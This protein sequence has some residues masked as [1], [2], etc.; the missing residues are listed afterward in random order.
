M[1]RQ[2]PLGRRTRLARSAR[3]RDIAGGGVMSNE[4]VFILPT[5]YITDVTDHPATNAA[6]ARADFPPGGSTTYD[7]KQTFY[8]HPPEGTPGYNG[9][10]AWE[11]QDPILLKAIKPEAAKAKPP[12]PTSANPA[13]PEVIPATDFAIAVSTSP[14]VCRAP[15]KPC[16]FPVFGQ[17][18]DEKQFA[19]TVRSNGLDLKKWDSA[20]TNTYGDEAGVGKGMVSG[21]QGDVVAPTSHS[22]IV[23]I[24]GQPIIRHRDS[25]TL[26]NGNCPGEYVHVQDVAAHEAPDGDDEEEKGFLGSFWSGMKRT[27][28]TAASGE[29]LVGKIG[30]YLDDPSAMGDDLGDLWESRPSVQDV[31]DFGS[32]AARGVYE[33]GKQTVTD[34]LGTAENVWEWGSGAASDAW[35]SGKSAWEE[36]GFAGATG[37]VLGVGVEV[38]NPFKK[39]EA[40]GDAASGAANMGKAAAARRRGD[41]DDGGDDNDDSDGE[42]GPNKEEE[43]GADGARSTR[44]AR[45]KCFEAPPGIDLDEL[46]RQLAEQTAAIKNMTADDMAYAHWVLERAGGTKK[47]RQPSAQRKARLE[48]REKYVRDNPNLTNAQVDEHMSGLHATHWLDMVAGGDPS[49]I[50]GLGGGEVNSHIGRQWTQDGRAQ[51]LKEQADAMRAAGRSHEKMDVELKRC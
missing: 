37:A 16:P 28:G 50:S 41:D 11:F 5:M 48:Y 12:P 6:I 7:E 19:V 34:P 26:N 33:A 36:D 31:K 3:G 23:R 35:E 2:F 39:V 17:A 13:P 47:L 10:D 8:Y 46:D 9:E 27:S 49:A 14:D 15:D 18:N 43:D 51:A 20:F 22:G 29:S 42:A 24:E 4:D 45:V 32:N 40:V 1:A 21:T 25:C 30:E 44:L 38:I